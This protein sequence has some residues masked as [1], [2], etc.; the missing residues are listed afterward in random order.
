MV[1]EVLYLSVVE[2]V[3][4]IG[5]FKCL[6]ASNKQI[7]VLILCESFIII[8][9]A[10]FCSYILFKEMVLLINQVIEVGLQLSLKGKFIQIDTNLLIFIYLTALNLGLVSSVFPAYF[11]SRLD[12]VVAL[13][14]Q[15]Y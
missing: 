14:Q 7:I 15:Y 6:G 8:S 10:Y 2:R 5:I 12:P 3:K 13:K 9:G 1:G 4:D 11:A